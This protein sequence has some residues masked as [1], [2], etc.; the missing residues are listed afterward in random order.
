MA[1]RKWNIEFGLV[2]FAFLAGFILRFAFAGRLAVEHFDEGIYTS[3]LWYDAAEGVEYPGRHLYAPPALPG[4]IKTVDWVP[5]IRWIAP[6]LPGLL[7]GA[8]TT[9]VV[10]WLV[11]TWFGSAAGIFSAFIV[12]GSDFHI[13]SSRMA[14]TDVPVLFFICLSVGWAAMGI[15]TS[16]MRRMVFAGFFCG[17]AWWTKYTGWLP[18]A[19]ISSGS[20]LWWI[21]TGRK[22]LSLTRL[23][24]L[25]AVMALTSFAVW[26]PWLWKLQDYGGYA[27]VAANHAGY[28]NGFTGWKRRLALQL[29]YQFTLD[30]LTGCLSVGMG[31][32]AASGYR[33][34]R[35]CQRRRESGGSESGNSTGSVA[36]PGH[37]S[38]TFPPRW[39]MARFAVSSLALSVIAFTVWT[40]LLLTSIAI[41]GIGGMLLW[42]VLDRAFQRSRSG[43]LSAVRPGGMGWVPGDLQCAPRID[44]TLGLCITTTWFIGM[45]VT[46][47]L[48]H[49]YPRLFLPLLAS[50]WVAASGGVGWWIESNLSVARRPAL[51]NVTGAFQTL[52]SRMVTAMVT[53]CVV[54]SFLMIVDPL[55]SVIFADRTSVRRAASEL[56]I[57]CVQDAG[58]ISTVPTEDEVRNARLVIY[59]YG[60]P[61]LLFHLNELGVLARPVSH[62]NLGAPEDSRKSTPTYLVVGPYA[63]RTPGFW[64]EWLERQ[65]QFRHLA[66][67]TFNP[68]ELVLLDLFSPEWLR[69]H[70][71]ANQQLLELYRIP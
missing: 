11:R 59:A 6:F 10:W 56:A 71:E 26:S 17:L 52:V 30:G 42:P 22:G 25:V 58:D 48:Y 4:T 33:W 43:D 5:G 62:L 50:I 51:E 20:G 44:P 65:Y 28:V 41:G 55:H 12:A 64:D 23:V 49:P 7:S 36:V 40:P 39:L 2:L 9:I 66:D 8:A 19:I 34:Y 68:G 63:K 47:P 67:V 27:S 15:Q 60:E 31:I 32:L 3:A 37:T 69:N 45:L 29:S 14:M 21:W 13:L 16:C 57:R 38:H 70:P 18:L 1:S 53:F 46:T 54:V 24:A 35:A 61:A